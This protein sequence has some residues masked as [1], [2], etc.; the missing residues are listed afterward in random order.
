MQQV[1]YHNNFPVCNFH[2][3]KLPWLKWLCFFFFGC[4]GSFMSSDC[5][6][7]SLSSICKV[8]SHDVMETQTSTFLKYLK[9]VM[10]SEL[11]QVF[12]NESTNKKTWNSYCHLQ[13]NGITSFF[14]HDNATASPEFVKIFKIAEG[15]TMGYDCLTKHVSL[16]C[17]KFATNWS[18]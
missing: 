15:N 8:L 9:R 10:F 7:N 17:N 11:M 16:K 14:F 1:L 5:F 3:L 12:D 6:S 4:D 18:L 2:W 13:C